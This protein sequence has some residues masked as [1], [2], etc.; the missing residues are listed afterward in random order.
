[1]DAARLLERFGDQPNCKDIFRQG[2]REKLLQL[3]SIGRDSIAFRAIVKQELTENPESRSRIMA[4]K[5][6]IIRILMEQG[7]FDMVL[8]MLEGLDLKAEDVEDLEADQD[9]PSILW[10][11][12][13]A[14]HIKLAAHIL[15]LYRHV[16][17]TKKLP[18][19]TIVSG[20]IA[21]DKRAPDGT[22]A[23]MIALA[24][25]NVELVETLAQS[26]VN[27]YD[28]YRMPKEG[29]ALRMIAEFIC[30]TSDE[31]KPMQAA[32]YVISAHR[33]QGIV[34]NQYKYIDN[35][36]VPEYPA[37]VYPHVN[38]QSEFTRGPLNL[39]CEKEL[40]SQG[41]NGRLT[42]ED[43]SRYIL[44]DFCI[45]SPSK[46]WA[47]ST[48]LELF[49]ECRHDSTERRVAVNGDPSG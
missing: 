28:I 17:L 35:E 36:T 3:F 7:Q 31:C 19:D 2:D 42:L 25:L 30:L 1:M 46:T 4:L 23:F 12:C 9:G 40:L 5:N 32:L 41:K 6:D 26:A 38:E 33:L 20:H 48:D 27:D 44:G 8:I 11:A 22:T 13:D 24:K 34:S 49:P 29:N 39:Q 43:C 21:L 47:V 10:Q 16:A 14:E 18:D 15:K 45:R 37:N